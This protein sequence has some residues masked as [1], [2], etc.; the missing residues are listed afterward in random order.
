MAGTDHI[1]EIC[2]KVPDLKGFYNARVRHYIIKDHILNVYNEFEKYFQRD[3]P[4]TEVENFK[5]FL[6]IHDIGKSIAYRNGD[7]NRQYDET[8]TLINKYK[9][10][11]NLTDNNLILFTSLLKAWTLGKYMENK[12]SLNDTYDNILEQAKISTLSISNFFHLLSVYYQCDI[13]SYT[14]DAGGLPYLEHLF[15]Y[16]N[17]NKIYCE[18]TNLLKLNGKYAKTYNILFD[19]IKESLDVTQVQNGNRASTVS[20]KDIQL[21]LVDKIDLSQF[22]KR[23]KEIK[24]NKE[25]LYIIDTNVFVDYPDIISKI[26]KEFPVILSAKVIDELDNLKSKLNNEG[27][28]NVQKALK[29]INGYLDTRD[30]RMEISDISLLPVDFNKRSPDNQILTVALKFKTEN[31]ILLTSDNGLQIK[32]KGLKLTT[33]SLTEFLSQL[34]RR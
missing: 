20:T 24:Q 27:K 2:K 9:T 23:K 1:D 7:T 34:K 21:K 32:A 11:L 13:A 15:E 33:I 29:S 17:G 22:E 16:Q 18:K 19:R 31:P 10:E 26:N 30:L 5:L 25:N 3:F 8:I 28:R 4:K 14:R 6:L 12:I